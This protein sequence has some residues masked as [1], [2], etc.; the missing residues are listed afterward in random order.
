MPGPRKPSLD[1]TPNP[2]P[3]PIP[4]REPMP[5]DEPEPGRLPDEEPNP[6]PPVIAS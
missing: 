2:L 4:G 3:P 5:I 1:E 6:N